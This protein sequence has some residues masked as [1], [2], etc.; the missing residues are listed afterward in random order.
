VNNTNIN[1]TIGKHDLNYIIDLLTSELQY[2]TR[3]GDEDD[4][5]KDIDSLIDKLIEQRG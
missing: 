3:E 1:I 2:I 4:I 5:A